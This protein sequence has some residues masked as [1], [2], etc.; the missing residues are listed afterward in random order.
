MAS[1]SQIA[2]GTLLMGRFLME[3]DADFTLYWRHL[4]VT[5]LKETTDIPLVSFT[6]RVTEVEEEEK[7]DESE[8]C[9]DNQ[10]N[11][12]K[13]QNTQQAQVESA[14]EKQFFYAPIALIL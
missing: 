2:G 14:E 4:N 1:T 13:Q 5:P 8:P 3:A 6:E 7:K 10:I 11:E 12:L 9:L